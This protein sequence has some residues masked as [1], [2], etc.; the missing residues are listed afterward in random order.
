[1]AFQEKKRGRKPK[2][3]KFRSY[4]GMGWDNWKFHKKTKE[5]IYFKKDE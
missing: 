5:G 1:M 3:I 4:E 2:K